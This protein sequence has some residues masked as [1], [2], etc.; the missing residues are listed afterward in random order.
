MV[1]DDRPTIAMNVRDFAWANRWDNYG[2]TPEHPH[3]PKARSKAES[4]FATWLMMAKLGSLD[5]LPPNELGHPVTMLPVISQ[6]E[7]P[8]RHVSWRR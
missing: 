5:D 6:V 1:R 3:R 2:L 7:P 8:M 4:D